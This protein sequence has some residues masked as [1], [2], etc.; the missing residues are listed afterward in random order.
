MSRPQ[1]SFGVLGAGLVLLALP[2]A[3][4]ANRAA[5]PA[6][7]ATLRR[8][9]GLP[10]GGPSCLAYL[11]STA[12]GDGASYARIQ[13]LDPL[14]A[15][16]GPLGP[17]FVITKSPTGTLGP[18][19]PVIPGQTTLA[20]CADAGVP[21]D[22]GADLAACVPSSA[23]R[24]P[25]SRTT[26]GCYPTDGAMDRLVARR[27]PSRCLVRRQV[28]LKTFRPQQSGS[29]YDLRGMKWKHWGTS[30]ATGTGTAAVVK[31]QKT[32]SKRVKVTLTAS[33]VKTDGG[34]LFYTKLRV[35]TPSGASTL[36]LNWPV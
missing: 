14:P 19:L 24:D 36:T 30:K 12:P 10:P 31:A 6:E 23:K 32:S 2:A 11:I 26:L 13:S 5:T 17:S 8:D 34:R 22:V 9:L 20:S 33:K 4:Q 25:K 35:R 18:W 1:V 28:D 3:A 21:N 7:A 29:G 16:C 27:K 15:G